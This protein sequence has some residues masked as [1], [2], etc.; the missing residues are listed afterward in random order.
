MHRLVLA[1]FFASG[2]G[3][4]ALI[5]V[6]EPPDAGTSGPPDAGPPP[7]TFGDGQL[8]PGEG[9]DWGS[10]HDN[11][12]GCDSRCKLEQEQRAT[13]M[14]L[15]YS[16]NAFCPANAIGRSVGAQLQDAVQQ[17][18]HSGIGDGSITVAW[19]FLGLTDPTGAGNQS[20]HI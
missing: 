15:Q 2:C 5:V 7:P 12:D 8:D 18:I 1:L 16:T 13:S 4:A 6:G 10:A 19:Q 9:C 3:N 20:L 14:Q 17:A 11:L